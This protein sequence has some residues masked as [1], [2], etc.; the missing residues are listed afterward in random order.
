ML[1]RPLAPA[2]LWSHIRIQTVD[3]SEARADHASYPAETRQS[4]DNFS[5]LCA[6]GWQARPTGTR[7]SIQ[8]AALLTLSQR[9]RCVPVPMSPSTGML[10]VRAQAS[11]RP[12]NTTP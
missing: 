4:S 10:L 3:R 8:L 2:N 5:H 9:D 7:H 11:V 12:H 1:S 6:I